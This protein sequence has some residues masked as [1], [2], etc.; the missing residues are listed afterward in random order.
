M[1]YLKHQHFTNVFQGY[2]LAPLQIS[3]LGTD[4]SLAAKALA[5][6]LQSEV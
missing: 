2:H 1:L 3:W 5:G 6:E 4:L